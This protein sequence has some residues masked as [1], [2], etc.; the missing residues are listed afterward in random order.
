MAENGYFKMNND[1][2][3]AL[4]RIR[5]SGEARQVLDFIIRKTDGYNKEWDRIP[6]SQF[7]KAT[8]LDRSNVVRAVVKLDTMRI[9]K[10]DTGSITKYMFNKNFGEWRPLSKKTRGVS[11]KTQTGV[12]KD[13]KPVSKKIHSINN[14]KDNIQKTSNMSPSQFVDFYHQRL[15]FG[16]KVVAITKKR[17]ASIKVRLREHPDKQFWIDLFAKI[18]Q[19][20]FLRGEVVPREG[21]KQFKL[22][23]EFVT[24]EN[25][26]AKIMEGEYDDRSGSTKKLTWR[27][28]QGSI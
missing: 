28:R 1:I 23:I 15:S 6:L 17:Q 7:V 14:T 8:G 3:D 19:S 25:K 18:S 24:N 26:I 13:N 11:K 22:N 5:I 27:E 2:Q 20:K 12:K 16:S 10:K 4:C 21:Y 9:I